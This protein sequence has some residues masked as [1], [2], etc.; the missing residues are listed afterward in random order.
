MV[1]QQ[2]GAGMGAN[3]PVKVT[4]DASLDTIVA[5]AGRLVEISEA[6]RSRHGFKKPEKPT[7]NP[8]A[9]YPATCG[10]PCQPPLKN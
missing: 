1:W 5:W 8:D 10:P 3:P 4:S 2:C 6:D 7:P 9:L